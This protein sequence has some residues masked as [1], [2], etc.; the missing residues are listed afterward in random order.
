[1]NRYLK[2]TLASLAGAT[3]LIVFLLAVASLAINPNDYKPQIV[4]MVKENNH[5]NL[6]LAG[7]IK[8]TF[9]PKLGLDLGQ[10]TLSEFRGEKEFAAVESARLYL[11]WWPLLIKK[12]VVDQVRIEGMRANLVRFKDGTTNFD[13]LLKTES[14]ENNKQ[15]S[16][17]IDSVRID[18]SA[19]SFQ[20]AM[21]GRR[22]SAS[23][24]T[25]KTGRLTNGLPTDV[26]AAFNLKSDNPLINAHFLMAAGVTFNTEAKQYAV[27]DLNLEIR[28]EAAG[29][30][31]LTAALKG[32]MELDLP[33]DMLLA[34]N[35]SCT[36]TGK[37][38]TDDVSIT[39]TA[40]RLQRIAGKVATDAIELS[41]KVR[42]NEG[43]GGETSLLASIPSL[44][45]D[46]QAF[47]TGTLNIEVNEKL[48]GTEYKGKLSSPLSGSF[49]DKQ[50][51][52]S[53]MKGSLTA[54]EGKIFSSGMK[55]ELAG[56]AQLD[57]ETSR[58]ALNLTSHLDESTLQ[59]K[60]EATP[61]TNPHI[62][63]D[64]DVDRI[65]ADRYLP[66]KTLQIRSQPEN[67]LD[68]S[69]L[70]TLNADGRV[71]IGSLKLYN[72]TTS[73]VRLDFKAGKG[74][75][76]IK[77]LTANLYQGTTSGSISLYADGPKIAA[78]Q[79][80]SGV[81]IAPLL[82]DG[83]NKDILEGTGNVTFDLQ[84]EGA[85]IAA[86]KKSLRGKAA[87]KLHDGAVKGFNIAAGLREAK[88]VLGVLQGEKIQNADMREKTDFSELSA[89]FAVQGGVASNKDLSARS[90]LLRVSGKGNIDIGSETLNYLVKATV[91]ASLE[92]Q[93]GREPASLKGV[94]VPVHIT[95]PFAS[96]KV[97]LDFNSL[98]TERVKEELKTRATDTLKEKLKG[99]FR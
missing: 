40:P 6:T 32:D 38:G 23:E 81:N 68:F 88:A 72:I 48:A 49:S 45:G 87:L 12:M 60:A 39:L 31:D 29:L 51:S 95:G 89:S 50:F 55:L 17:D 11:S 27:K 47:K 52:L 15:I 71:R 18:K 41:A 70:K 19:L 76:D 58:A 86:M 42:K 34:E 93:G 62:A 69:M 44:A 7:N 83:L 73:N 84:A 92:G 65:D 14:K 2:Y 67:P 56:S 16:F 74:R 90:P 80:I 54:N 22:F 10:T 98:A 43:D 94:T 82:K 46:N 79:N 30:S 64:L 97:G 77:P 63:L 9:F 25:I 26:T 35:L 91:V 61:F 53:K 78:L 75:L 37:K 33:G 57:L 20:D 28:G 85:S 1:M 59:L 5:R 3:I 21:A 13:D 66:A 96:P 8:L 24:I 4:Q 99:L 36:L